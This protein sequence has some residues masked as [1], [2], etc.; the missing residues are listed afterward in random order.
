MVLPF[1]PPPHMVTLQPPNQE[2]S[3]CSLSGRHW[4]R[5]YDKGGKGRVGIED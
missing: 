2:G 5:L 4:R 1:P 3:L